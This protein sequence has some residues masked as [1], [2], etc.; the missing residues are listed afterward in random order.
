MSTTTFD[1]TYI[2]PVRQDAIAPDDDLTEYLRFLSER[3]EV[4]I[5]DGSPPD[6]FADHARRWGKLARHISPEPDLLTLNGKVGGVVTGLRSARHERL[7]IADDDVRYD[8][9]GLERM[10]TALET[11]DVVR[12]QNYFDPHPWHA[13]W[14]TARSLLNR[15]TGGDWP[16]TL[17]VRRSVLI[18]TGGYDGGV[19]FENLEMVRTVRSA[20]GHEAVLLDTFVRRA[21]PNAQDFWSQRVRQAYD[22]FARPARLAVWLAVIPTVLGLI[23]TRRWTALC[24][25]PVS[26]IALAES[27]RRRAGGRSVFPALASLLAPAWVM[28]RAVCSWMA[29]G[30]RLTRGGVPYRGMVLQRAATPM[31]ILRRRHSGSRAGLRKAA[32][33]PD[34]ESP[35][36]MP[37]SKTSEPLASEC[38][39]TVDGKLVRVDSPGERPSSRGEL[40]HTQLHALVSSPGF[41]C[42]GAKSVFRQEQYRLGFYGELGAPETT[43]ALERDLNKFVEAG[44]PDRG[45]SSFIATFTGPNP[46]SETEFETLLWSQL[47]SLHERDSK[48]HAWDTSVSSNPQDPHFSFSVAGQ[49]FFV[50]GLHAASSRW[51]RRFAWPTLVFN[52]HEQF[53]R[54]RE[55]GSFPGLQS[56]IREREMALQGSLN[57]N[58]ANYGDYSE[59]RQYSGRPAEAG[60]RCPFE[61]HASSDQQNQHAEGDDR[62]GQISISH[63]PTDGS[64]VSTPSGEHASRH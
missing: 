37:R 11:A 56:R 20:G 45:F 12:P 52:P 51:A 39:E 57:A 61:P 2:L 15:M 34:H 41:S 60:W 27:G 13:L 54:L 7:I 30:L 33:I 4:L 29:V 47:Q 62:G 42:L 50:V 58:L 23:V 40:V 16:G 8:E 22:E 18:A 64:S 53:E 25:L 10:L 17:G 19:L 1:A 63:Q 59:A 49:A 36:S 38:L 44:T 26:I 6:I 5:V 48:L 21:P 55:E 28:E 32:A 35:S 43:A 46:S 9:N 24:S 31:R 14:D 3:L